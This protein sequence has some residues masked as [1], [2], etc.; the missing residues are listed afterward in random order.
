MPTCPGKR[1]HQSRSFRRNL[2]RGQPVSDWPFEG[3]RRVALKYHRP[4]CATRSHDLG[5]ARLLSDLSCR[6]RAGNLRSALAYPRYPPSVDRDR[7]WSASSCEAGGITPSHL[8]ALEAEQRRSPTAVCMRAALTVSDRLP[9]HLFPWRYLPR[10]LYA[11]PRHRT[12]NRD[13]RT[14][15]PVHITQTAVPLDLQQN[16]LAPADAEYPRLASSTL[17][18]ARARSERGARRGQAPRARRCRAAPRRLHRVRADRT[19]SAAR[20]ARRRSR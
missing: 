14:A 7:D 12:G 19:R 20:R 9:V 17:F 6:A 16:A 2:R 8:W 1:S 10:S 18:S 4:R 15:I 13:R 11:V 5:H 3:R